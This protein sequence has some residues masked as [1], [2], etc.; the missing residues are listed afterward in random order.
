MKMYRE[1]TFEGEWEQL[2]KYLANIE[3]RL[4]DGWERDREIEARFEESS[5]K[6]RLTG[7]AER[8]YRCAGTPELP[9]ARLW[10]AM[11]NPLSLYVPNVTPIEPRDLSYDEYNAIVEMFYRA[12][13][14]P[15]A[16]ACG[17][18]VTLGPDRLELSEELPAGV[19]QA[20]REFSKKANR[21][22]GS[23]R[24][25]DRALWQRFILESHEADVE[26]A[27]LTLERWLAEDEGWPEDVARELADEYEFGRSLLAREHGVAAT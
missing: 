3:E 8:A 2:E 27:R 12:Y 7:F 10:I 14:L 15:P 21:S 19:F 18:T 24:K 13:A 16:S 17:V 26:L 22:L 25:Q 9:P 20:L 23:A 4:S 1:L 6:G 11:K 5:L